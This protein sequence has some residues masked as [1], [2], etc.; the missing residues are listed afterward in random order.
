MH[1]IKY[2]F[3]DHNKILINT[4]LML[5]YTLIGLTAY[6]K[7]TNMDIYTYTNMNMQINHT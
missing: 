1:P 4:L 3:I 6:N 2:G 7:H 5:F